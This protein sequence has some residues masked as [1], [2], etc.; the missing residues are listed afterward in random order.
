MK[1]TAIRFGRQLLAVVMVVVMVALV[2]CSSTTTTPTPAA[3]APPA[4]TA[5]PTTPA[6]ALIPPKIDPIPFEKVG[7]IPEP[8]EGDISLDLRLPVEGIVWG[9]DSLTISAT[10]MNFIY[11]IKS[12]PENH[13]KMGKVAIYLDVEP[14]MVPGQSG[15]TEEGTYKLAN[16]DNTL[17]KGIADGEHTI[18]VQLLNND[19]TVIDTPVME[20]VNFTIKAAKEA[21]EPYVHPGPASVEFVSPKEGEALTTS[22]ELKVV[23]AV[24]NFTYLEDSPSQ[25]RDGQGKVAVYLDVEP[26]LTPGEKGVDTSKGAKGTYKLSN[27]DTFI[28]TDIAPGSHTLHAQLLD[29]LG[30]VLATPVTA[31]ITF[32]SP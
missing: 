23:V 11:T 16:G 24:K 28:W 5:K 17:W 8:P 13:P 7:I 4:T 9:S 32:T 21:L 3:T 30:N 2:G 25:V 29:N 15:L 10:P 22:S 1:R 14:P 31:K 6:P 27:M 18:Y 20:K 12:P 19:N 26:I